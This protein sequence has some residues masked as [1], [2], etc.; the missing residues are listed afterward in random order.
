MPLYD[1][2]VKAAVHQHAAF[3]VHLRALG[4]QPEIA[5]VK[6]FLD[7]CDG[8]CAVRVQSHYGKAHAIVAH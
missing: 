8:I 1:M 3:E 6:G 7:G 4:K 2:S 5:A